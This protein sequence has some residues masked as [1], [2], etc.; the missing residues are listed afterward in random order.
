MIGQKKQEHDDKRWFYIND[1]GE[2]IFFVEQL[3]GQLNK[4][5]KIGDIAIQHH[6]DIVALAWSGFRF[7]LQ[8]LHHPMFEPSKCADIEMI[9]VGTAYTDNM[10]A[11]SE[12]LDQ[13]VRILYCCD[14]YEKLYVGKMLQIEKVLNESLVNLYV[15]VLEYLSYA[16]SYVEKDMGGRI[17]SLFLLVE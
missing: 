15:S 10:R 2:K 8:V 1:Q 17:C 7:L 11:V 9:Q 14:I 16:L 4:Y 12:G 5:A 3:L 13:V 6:P